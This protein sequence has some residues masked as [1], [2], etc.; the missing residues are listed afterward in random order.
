MKNTSQGVLGGMAMN[1]PSYIPGWWVGEGCGAPRG[2]KFVTKSPQ[3]D[4]RGFIFRP[5]SSGKMSNSYDEVT[6]SS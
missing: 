3:T 5:W 4:A 6:P 1:A 2:S